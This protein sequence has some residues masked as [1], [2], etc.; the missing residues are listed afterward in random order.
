MSILDCET[1][2]IKYPVYAARHAAGCSDAANHLHAVRLAVS[3]N[4][5]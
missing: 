5:P 2:N 3:M 4:R 1:A